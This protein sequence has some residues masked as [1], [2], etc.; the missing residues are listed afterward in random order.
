MG[1]FL[2]NQIRRTTV[3]DPAAAVH[4]LR[5]AVLRARL[6]VV[7]LMLTTVTPASLTQRMLELATHQSK[8]RLE[9]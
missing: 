2:P 7:W 6:A 1:A 5:T 3:G 4:E 9:P 8:L